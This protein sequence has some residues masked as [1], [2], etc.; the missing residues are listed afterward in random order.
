MTARPFRFLAGPGDALDRQSLVEHARRVEDLGYDALVMSDHLLKMLAPLPALVSVAEATG[1]L[2]VGTFVLNNDLRHPAVLAQE[3]ASIDQLTGGRLEIG[4]GAGWNRPEYD[5][6]GFSFDAA[7]VRVGRMEEA[8]KVLKGLMAEGPFSFDGT[9]YHIT[10]MEGWPKPVQRPHPPLMIGGGGRRVMRITG[11]EAQILSVAPRV[12]TSG[13]FDITDCLAAGTL[14]KIGWAREAAGDR[15]GDLEIMTYAPLLPVTVT[16]DPRAVARAGV[17]RLRERFGVELTEEQLL[18]SPHAFAG[19]V[20]GLVEKCLG[21]RERFGITAVMVGG[22]ADA[23]APVVAR[24][25]G[26]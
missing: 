5:A 22:G 16:D 19:T 25:A 23:F 11:R 8:I 26:R 14:E 1:R 12:G 20:D 18:D 3:L 4:L 9:H 10:E 7:G 24:L 17:D 2:R 6:A 13:P 21:L 15:A